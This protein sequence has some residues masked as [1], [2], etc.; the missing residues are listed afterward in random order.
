MSKQFEDTF[1]T[2]MNDP[3]LKKQFDDL[4]G[5]AEQAGLFYLNF[6]AQQS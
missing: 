4:A 1:A 5:S 3:N 2:L 6:L